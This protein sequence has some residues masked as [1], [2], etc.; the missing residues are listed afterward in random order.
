MTNK[1]DEKK[2]PK[3]AP[4][5][6]MDDIIKNTPNRP[7][8]ES[9]IDG[10]VIAKGKM[11]LFVDLPPYGTGMIF[12]REY[13]NA[14]DLIKKIN[15]GDTVT[16]KVVTPEGEDGYIE[17]SLKEAKQAILWDKVEQ[18]M[19]QKEVFSLTVKDVNKGG[20]II[21]WEGIDGFLPASQ[22]KP[23]NY[24]RVPD[25]D[26]DKII[27]EL[28][29]MKGTNVDVII[30]GAEPKEGKLIF[31]E[32]N[33][34]SQSRKA[35]VDSFNVG[36][37]IEGEVTGAVDFGIFIKIEEG[38]EGLVHISELNWSL[39]EDPRELYKAGDKIKAKIIEIKD[40]KISLSIKALKPNPW[41]EVEG[42]FKKGDIVSGVVIKYNKHGALVSIEEGVAGLVHISDF[43]DE[44]DIRSKLEL[45]KTYDFTINLFEPKHQRMTLML[46]DRRQEIE[47]GDKSKTDKD[48]K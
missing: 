4:V 33:L 5:S 19:K 14:R 12:G 22:L 42:K 10:R 11:A 31:S 30:I 24:P 32:K 48:S 20:L 16:A 39:V 29:K 1:V 13:F 6:V 3:D 15:I 21:S 43:A 35:I 26:K 46:G 36:D 41:D 47:A 40:D 37:V 9:L 23:E 2:D 18:S 27:E 34:D 8:I 44:N 17:L 28:E 38:L 7:E 25:G 45:G